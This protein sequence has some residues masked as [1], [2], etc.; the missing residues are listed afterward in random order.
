MEKQ[1]ITSRLTQSE[2]KKLKSL[3]TKK[4]RNREKL[5]I[6][7]GIRV[8]EESLKFRRWPQK[9]YYAPSEIAVR[10]KKLIND[11]RN[12]SIPI[13]ASSAKAL[14][15]LSDAETG[16]GVLGLFEIPQ[17]IDDEL[18]KNCHYVLLLDNISDPGNAGTLIRSALAFGFDT[19]LFL[20]NS[21]DPYNPK[22]VRSTAGAIFGLK[23]KTVEVADIIY[24]RKKLKIPL[25]TADLNGNRMETE[26]KKIKSFNDFIF[27]IGSERAGLSTEIK[28][29]AD[30]SLRIDHRQEV[31][32]LNA[33]VAGS[34]IMYR[35]F[36]G[37]IVEVRA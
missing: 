8:L 29:L 32:S 33:A 15:Q 16:Q 1:A 19:V 21:V 6:A 4:G 30:L 22:V 34:I 7:E 10:A 26:L 37:K 2:K 17:Y 28:K 25:I 23:V 3:L 31:E 5:F 36:S 18:I 9:V 24:I 35:L 11:F 14:N 27:A 20:S 12:L 13:Q